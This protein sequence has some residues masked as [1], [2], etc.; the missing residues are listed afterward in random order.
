MYL[1]DSN[2][3]IRAF[4]DPAVGQEL[5]R[6]HAEHLSRL[7]LSAVVASELLVGAL[8]PARE[9]GLR[10]GLLEPFRTRRRFHVPSWATWEL[11]T[12]IDRRLRSRGG[13]RASLAQRGFFHDILIAATARELG[14][15]IITYNVA[16][17]ALIARVVA[18]R[19]AAPWPF[20]A[21]QSRT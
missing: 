10:R 8:S 3:Y 17:F 11:A 21:E 5:Q 15:T 14:A 13:L 1:L 19:F 20:A 12:S 2:V 16:D 18:I 4:V 7:V 6:F 9:R